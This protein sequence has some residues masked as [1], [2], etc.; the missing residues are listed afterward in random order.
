MP[1]VHIFLYPGRTIK[2]KEDLT[3]RIVSDLNE[4]IGASNDV[5]SVSY[6]EVSPDKWDKDVVK[7]FIVERKQFLFKAP[8]Y[9]I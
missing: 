8:E 6:E 9:K 3:K 4:I 2:Q 7:P 1:H 5:I